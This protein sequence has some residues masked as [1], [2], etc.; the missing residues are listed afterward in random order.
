MRVMV[1]FYPELVA[2]S[3]GKK[4]VRVN[5]PGETVK[6]LLHYLALKGSPEKRG[7][8]F[9]DKGE[10]SPYILVLINGKYIPGLDPHSRRLREHDSVELTVALG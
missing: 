5:F 8:L 1:K 9:T 4:E 2:I 10:I 7:I 3:K 6:D